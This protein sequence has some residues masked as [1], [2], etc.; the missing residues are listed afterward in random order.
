MQQKFDTI[1]NFIGEQP[2]PNYVPVKWAKKYLGIDSIVSIFTERTEKINER[3]NKFYSSKLQLKAD[4]WKVDPYDM[5]EIFRTIETIL[6][7]FDNPIFNLT[8][9][10][11]PMTFAG[12]SLAMKYK[13]P[14]LYFQTEG[15]KMVIKVYDTQKSELPELVENILIEDNIYNLEEYLSVHFD[16]FH[17]ERKRGQGRFFREDIGKQLEHEILEILIKKGFEII[18]G[19]NIPPDIQIDLFVRHGHHV[20]IVEVKKTLKPHAINQIALPSRQV[21]LG[22]YIRRIVIGGPSSKEN[23]MKNILDRAEIANCYVIRL[24]SMAS[25]KISDYDKE[26]LVNELKS[27]LEDPKPWKIQKLRETYSKNKNGGTTC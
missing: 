2:I 17:K 20:G 4:G 10:T 23:D 15:G 11:K 7:K 3:L 13:F 26:K 6:S 27:W 21:K 16:E 9:G 18:W 22:T 12:Y 1:I 24:D 25:G 8:G 19:V 14:F 5:A